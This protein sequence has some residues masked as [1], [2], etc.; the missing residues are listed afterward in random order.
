MNSRTLLLRATE[1]SPN[2]TEAHWLAP[3]TLKL[4]GR[5]ICGQHIEPPV[6]RKNQ[7]E[8]N[9]TVFWSQKA[10]KKVLVQHLTTSARHVCDNSHLLQGTC[11]AVNMRT[12][13]GP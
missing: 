5:L 9:M 6:A 10:D 2:L 12:N 11:A 3:L 7:K 13:L 4:L 8:S 1:S